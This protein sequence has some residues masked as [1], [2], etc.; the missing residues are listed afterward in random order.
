[1]KQRVIDILDDSTGKARDTSRV[2]YIFM[3]LPL[4]VKKSRPKVSPPMVMMAPELGKKCFNP[5][6][7]LS[8]SRTLEVFGRHLF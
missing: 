7:L 6:Q 3:I 8:L 2:G 1:V 5:A 4:P